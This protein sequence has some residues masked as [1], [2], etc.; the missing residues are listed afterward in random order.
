MK[1]KNKEETELIQKAKKGDKDAFVKLIMP[2]EKKLK[3]FI[4]KRSM[5]K[6]DAED[7]FQ[8]VWVALLERI[9]KLDEKKGVIA[10]VLTVARYK[11]MDKFRNMSRQKEKLKIYKKYLE[12][13]QQASPEDKKNDDEKEKLQ[14]LIQIFEQLSPLEKKVARAKLIEGKSY[15]EIAKNPKNE[16]ELNKLRATFYRAK[17]KIAN[18]LE[19]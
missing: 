2:Y 12:T 3:A 13:K 11:C 8:E 6:S 18:L 9:D 16:R 5:S 4:R 17:K 15:K 7:V 1:Q 19:A 14:K 10:W